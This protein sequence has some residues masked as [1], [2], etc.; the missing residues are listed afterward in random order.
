MHKL[1]WTQRRWLAIAVALA[2]TACQ[3]ETT[4]DSPSDAP[5]P[6]T[7]EQ[8][9]LR[10]ATLEQAD[11]DGE[12]LWKINA[13]ETRYSDDKQAAELEG[14][15]GNLLQDGE[16]ILKVRAERGEI[17][18]DEE[19][20][21]KIFLRGKIEATDPRNGLMI[22][23][24]ELDWFPQDDRV[25]AREALQLSH[26]DL[27]LVAAEARYRTRQEELDLLGEVVATAKEQP[28][29]LESEK[30]TWFIG[31]RQL[32]SDRGIALTRYQPTG[33][34]P[35]INATGRSARLG[36]GIGAAQPLLLSPPPLPETVTDRVVA[37]VAELNLDTL[38]ALL[39]ESVESRSLEPP[40]QI[41]SNSIVWDLK[42]RTVLADAPVQIQHATDRLTV[43]AN[44]GFADLD[45]ETV[46]LEGGARGTNPNNN[47]A[48][49]ADELL[50]QIPSQLVEAEGSVVYQQTDPPLHLVGSRAVGN[51]DQQNIT[52]TSGGG[53]RVVTNIVP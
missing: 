22:R 31:D 14:L 7:D 18:L 39:Q 8:L 51:L 43:A 48:L 20:G 16:P 30:I 49:S 53:E 2:L 37:Q 40:L 42:Q 26:A 3:P 34:Q 46:Q 36:L 44:Q 41:A 19:D 32:T 25:V 28:L 6:I 27:E 5:E 13:R 29:Q 4:S 11:D 17:R 15:T 12:I 45:A 33:T 23:A 52:I 21:E 35:A 47:S 10:N 9:T 50:W 38:V 1:S 24:R